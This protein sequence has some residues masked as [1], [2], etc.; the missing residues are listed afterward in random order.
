MLL[1][2]KLLNQKMKVLLITSIK[3]EKYIQD[4]KESGCREGGQ[5]GGAVPPSPHHFLEQKFF[6]H[7]KSENIKFS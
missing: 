2:L 3:K 6:F 1:M 5:E 4:H 7:V